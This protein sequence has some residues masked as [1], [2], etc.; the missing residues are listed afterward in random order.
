MIE[1][2]F[3]VHSSFLEGRKVYPTAVEANG[4]RHVSQF[5]GMPLQFDYLDFMPEWG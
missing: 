4:E 5:F 1:F 3:L 2:E